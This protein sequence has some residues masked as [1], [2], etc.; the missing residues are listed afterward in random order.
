MKKLSIIAIGLLLSSAAIAQQNN[1]KSEAAS[2]AESKAIRE[3]YF[4]SVELEKNKP[5]PAV[6]PQTPTQIKV[7]GPRDEERV[8][9]AQPQVT[10]VTK[11]TTP[12]SNGPVP[13]K[14]TRELTPD[15][16]K[17]QQATQSGKGGPR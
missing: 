12:T 2:N 6:V 10:Q 9:V 5:A 4:K 15:E 1:T 14:K 17:I 7:A 3:A 13:T 8:I 11:A 16:L